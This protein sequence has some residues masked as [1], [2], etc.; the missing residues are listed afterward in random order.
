MQA[1]GTIGKTAQTTRAPQ[2]MLASPPPGFPSAAT[3]PHQRDR[4]AEHLFHFALLH[5]VIGAPA[6]L[7]L[8]RMLLLIEEVVSL[9]IG[10]FAAK[11]IAQLQQTG[12]PMKIA[13]NLG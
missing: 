3:G 4:S 1:R 2:M 5:G 9:Q 13:G 8:G 10:V 6:L 7:C 12:Q 11:S